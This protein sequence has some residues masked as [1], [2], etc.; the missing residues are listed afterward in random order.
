MR[1][2]DARPGL[3]VE[4]FDVLVVL[5]GTDMVY[6]GR[7]AMVIDG[8]HPEHVDDRRMTLADFKAG[9]TILHARGVTIRRE[10]VDD[11]FHRLDSHGFGSI[12]Y[13]DFVG[14]AT[15]KSINADGDDVPKS[16]LPS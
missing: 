11:E 16:P 3:L 14:W 6:F 15:A 1:D 10:D 12:D 7:T 2:A 5:G 9:L 4:G 13:D 8:Q